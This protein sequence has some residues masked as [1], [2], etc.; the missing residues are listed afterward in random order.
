MELRPGQTDT[1]SAVDGLFWAAKQCTSVQ[2]Q[3]CPEDA[4]GETAE[5]EDE[6]ATPVTPT[7]AGP[8]LVEMGNALTKVCEEPLR[9][10]DVETDDHA[11]PLCVKSVADGKIIRFRSLMPFHSDALLRR[12]TIQQRRMERARGGAGKQRGGRSK[13][14]SPT[15]PMKTDWGEQGSTVYGYASTQK[16]GMLQTQT[17]PSRDSVWDLYPWKDYRFR[18]KRYWIG[19]DTMGHTYLF[20]LANVIDDRIPERIAED[21]EDIEK[22]QSIAHKFNQQFAERLAS[23]SH[24]QIGGF[25][26]G[27]AVVEKLFFGEDQGEREHR[28]DGS[29]FRGLHQSAS[30]IIPSDV[31]QIKIVRSGECVVLESLSE[32][33]I[34]LKSSALLTWLPAELK[35]AAKNEFFTPLMKAVG[36]DID[37]FLFDGAEPF[38]ELAATFFH[39]S[40]YISSGREMITDLQGVLTDDALLLLDPVVLRSSAMGAGSYVSS[41][42]LNSLFQ[43][44]YPKATRTAE[45]FDPQRTA[46]ARRQVC[47]ISCY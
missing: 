37:K 5:V 47:G 9:L 42:D 31:P 40:F 43:S 29:S 39:Y 4:E 15:S 11:T 3:I 25:G 41:D 10:C 17:W 24:N 45:S 19:T 44:L 33:L 30:P 38:C 1:I 21:I 32:N 7:G 13:G 46:Y 18:S 23:T 6:V 16:S 27:A 35:N 22:A 14:G 28:G 34:P 8:D 36:N 2:L 20:A 26:G 12:Y